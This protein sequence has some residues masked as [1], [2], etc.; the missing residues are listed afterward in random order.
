VANNLQELRVVCPTP[1]GGAALYRL[2]RPAEGWPKWAD[3]QPKYRRAMEQVR[4][5]QSA[6]IADPT[7]NNSKKSYEYSF[8]DEIMNELQKKMPN[9]ITYSRTDL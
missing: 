5:R 4:N 2:Q 8:G 1:D 7:I 6:E 3:L 9:G